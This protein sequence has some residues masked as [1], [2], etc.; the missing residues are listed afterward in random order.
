[1]NARSL[2]VIATVAL[3]MLLGL[4]LRALRRRRSSSPSRDVKRVVIVG[5]GFAGVYAA[6]ELEKL[7]RGR[8]DFDIVLVSKE[9]YFVFQPMLPEVI[10][11]SIGLTDVVSPLRRLLRT[12]Q[13][14]VRDVESIDTVAKVVR[15][16]PGYHAKEH[17]IAYD[18]LI[19]ATGI[20]TDFRGLTGLPEHALPFKNLGD[21]LELRTQ[22][23]HAL[24]EADIETHDAKLKRQLCT[25]VVAGGGFSGVEVVAEL[26]DFVRRVARHYRNIDPAELR[27]VLLQ[28]QPRILPEM[29]EK[30]GRFAA[31]LLRKRG[32]EIR[33]G[34]R[35]AAATGSDAVLSDGTR[36]PTKTLVSTVPSSPHPLVEA[37]PL[38][39]TKAGKLVVDG[40]LRVREARDVWALGDCAHVPTL[41]RDGT[42]GEGVPAPPTAQHATR[43]AR[44]VARNI[45]AALDGRPQ[46]AFD[47]RG[48]GK[49]GSL[50]HRN[51]V[52]E[53]FGLSISG[54]IAWFLWRT[55]YLMK[56]PG[57]GRRI[58]VAASWTFELFLPPD[59]AQLRLSTSTCMLKQHYEPGQVVFAEGDLGDRIY[60]V[61][62]GRA[63]VSRT[64]A[65]VVAT[66][67]PGEYFGEMALL[68][69]T[70]RDATVRCVE[71]MDVLAIDK[72]EYALLSAH[73]PDL[74][75]SIERVQ[76]VRQAS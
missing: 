47:F 61:L 37:L 49:M 4:L 73:V 50:G 53:V 62:A 34:V 5:G 29:P 58:K 66:V 9:N 24:E 11:G 40:M 55:V 35:L 69:A 18:H 75:R 1:M 43:Q 25:F 14:V 28:S 46:V 41:V 60:I 42:S 51:A 13:V 38:P 65:G 16:A 27:I 3:G 2:F 17:L 63:E 15:A 68:A 59:L 70:A 6:R 48:F 12:T 22:V 7:Q 56:L 32:V 30:L 10:S 31:E 45:V 52:A 19:L 67:G 54:F 36:I 23:I 8:N 21:A 72:R 44:T 71:A 20:V 39:K 26:N 33:L 64:D 76:K 57:W 74:R